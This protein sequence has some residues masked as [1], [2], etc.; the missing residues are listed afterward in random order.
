[1]RTYLKTYKIFESIGN[2]FSDEF[3]NFVKDTCLDLTDINYKVNISEK[4]HS[5]VRGTDRG[6][7]RLKPG[8][9][10][11]TGSLQIEVINEDGGFNAVIYPVIEL[12]QSFSSEYN[13]FVDIYIPYHHKY[14]ESEDIKKYNLYSKLHTEFIIIIY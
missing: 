11:S 10:V 6:F 5:L 8:D 7:N 9:K 1:M 4:T 13:F 2:K 12:I 3:I 14:V